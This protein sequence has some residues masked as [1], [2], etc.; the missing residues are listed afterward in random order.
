MLGVFSLIHFIVVFSKRFVAILITLKVIIHD[1]TIA[2]F[3]PTWNLVLDLLEKVSRDRPLIKSLDAILEAS[4][5]DVIFG[6]E[7]FD[8]LW[9]S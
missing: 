3:L 5:L 4:L 6:L 7:L 9:S 1:I 2:P 8:Q